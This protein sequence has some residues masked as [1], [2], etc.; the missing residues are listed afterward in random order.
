MKDI[1]NVI[2][3]V[4]AIVGGWVGYFMGGMDGLLV[5]LICF[6]AIDYVT[7]IGCAIV[8]KTLSSQTGFK[9]I[10]K[11]MVIFLLVGV[12]N[13]LDRQV[14]G[15]GTALRSAVILFYLSNE[16][17]SLL[18]NAGHLGLPIPARLK[19]ILAQLHDREDKNA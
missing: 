3:A 15:T 6:V 2:Q 17:I 8:D 10:C 11:K 1:W 12:A 4:L 5:A 13:V 14:I 16:G 18:E 7:G 9:G 19:E